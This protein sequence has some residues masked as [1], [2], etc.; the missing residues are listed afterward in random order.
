[1]VL[2]LNLDPTLLN[3]PAQHHFPCRDRKAVGQLP[4][5]QA[6]IL[7]DRS[8]AHVGAFA[9]TSAGHFLPQPPV[10]KL[11]DRLKP[12]NLLTTLVQWTP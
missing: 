11:S 2:A 12:N 8:L 6:Q 9:R 1:M 7:Q 4:V 10:D 5:G 3:H